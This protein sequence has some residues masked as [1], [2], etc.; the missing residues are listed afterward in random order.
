MKKLILAKK[1]HKLTSF[2]S[3]VFSLY[4]FSIEGKALDYSVFFSYFVSDTIDKYV[5]FMD[6]IFFPCYTN[7]NH[8]IRF[9]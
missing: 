7:N 1:K 5:D 3:R 8:S 4:T 6:D 2:F 9:Y